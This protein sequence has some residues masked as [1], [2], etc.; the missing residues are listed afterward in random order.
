MEIH[1]KNI[2][3]QAGSL[4]NIAM[5]SIKR[6][7]VIDGAST[8]EPLNP[9]VVQQ[10]HIPNNNVKNDVEQITN[11]DWTHQVLNRTSGKYSTFYAADYG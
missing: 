11:K 2:V 7:N 3:F 1:G 5:Y 8:V 6:L 9:L 4:Q 10:L